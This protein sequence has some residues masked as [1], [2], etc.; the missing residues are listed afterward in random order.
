MQVLLKYFPFFFDI[1]N[2]TKFM[3]NT[4]T[5]K[6]KKKKNTYKF[7]FHFYH[8]HSFLVHTLSIQISWRPFSTDKNK[9]VSFI[10]VKK[11]KQLFLLSIY[12]LCV[13]P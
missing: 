13:L 2:A 11:K 8:H 3:N 12:Q 10:F 7:P 1:S 5:H 4:L 6:K 9:C